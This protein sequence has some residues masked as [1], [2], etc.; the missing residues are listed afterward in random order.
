MPNKK[1]TLNIRKFDKSERNNVTDSA[2]KRKIKYQDAME[3]PTVVVQVA[4]E[5]P[6]TIVPAREIDEIT[7]IFSSKNRKLDD[8]PPKEDDSQ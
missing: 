5:D 3:K 4:V 6:N 8:Y 7:V 1:I 2:W